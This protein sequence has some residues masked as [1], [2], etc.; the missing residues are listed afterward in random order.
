[1]TLSKNHISSV[2]NQKNHKKT[3][4]FCLKVTILP[5]CPVLHCINNILKNT[6]L[7]CVS[8]SKKIKFEITAK[9]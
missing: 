4:R 6:V 1:M 3:K 8:C 9:G 2:Q 5:A 7:F